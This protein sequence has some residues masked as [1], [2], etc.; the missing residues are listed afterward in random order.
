MVCIASS[1]GRMNLAA[2]LF[3]ASQIPSGNPMIRQKNT[4]VSTN[5]KVV[6]A[7]DQAP[8]SPMKT[9]EANVDIPKRKLE[10]CHANK[11]RMMS[12][13]GA[14]VETSAVSNEE[15]MKSMGTRIA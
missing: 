11:N 10:N 7:W 5:A 14:G 15:R 3:L 6:I 12:M 1:M 13:N 2:V 8:I 4:D 9:N